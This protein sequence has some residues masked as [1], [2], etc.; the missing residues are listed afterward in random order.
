ML[1]PDNYKDFALSCIL[2][3]R[4]FE[5][6]FNSTLK[7]PASVAKSISKFEKT[8]DAKYLRVALNEVVIFFNLFDRTR[9]LDL[10]FYLAPDQYAAKAASLVSI[11]NIDTREYEVDLDFKELTKKE[12]GL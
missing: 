6:E 3:K 1:T 9:G 12:I 10:F 2:V 8:G 5:E 4:V 7:R 11:F